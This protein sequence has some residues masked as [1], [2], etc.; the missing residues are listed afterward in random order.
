LIISVT[1]CVFLVGAIHESPAHGSELHQMIE[2][3]FAACIRIAIQEG[4]SN[5][6]LHHGSRSFFWLI[7]RP[8]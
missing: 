6:P 8:M 7:L 5:A 1:V 4:A 2:I 3:L